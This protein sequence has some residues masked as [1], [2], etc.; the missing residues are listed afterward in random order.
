LF[1]LA[2]QPIVTA[3]LRDLV[4]YEAFLRMR[5]PGFGG[6]RAVIQRAER[7]GML[8][9]LSDDIFH[10]AADR[11][12]SLP[13]DIGLFVNVHPAELADPVA[14]RDRLDVLLPFAD[15]VNLELTERSATADAP[16]WRQSFSIARE[17]GFGLAIA[18]LGTQWEGVSV[19]QDLAPDFVK[20]DMSLV[21]DIHKHAYKRRVAD[22][23]CRV[24][25]CMGATVVAEGVETSEEEAVLVKCGAN[26]LQGYLFGRPR[27]AVDQ[28][29]ATPPTAV[30]A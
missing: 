26:L 9:D 28:Q 16:A 8:A 30:P 19:V 6:P 21:R 10:L 17:R 18:D 27:L 14:F 13:A 1:E 23:L 5:S 20:L 11:V 29:P 25:R 7:G 22:V 4:A 15:R 12:R 2:L 3:G 24:A